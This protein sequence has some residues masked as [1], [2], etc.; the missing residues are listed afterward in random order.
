MAIILRPEQ[1]ADYRETENVT[2]EA[3]WNQYAPGC[4]EHY[5][6]HI[7]RHHNAFLPELDIVAVD[8]KQ[9]IGNIVYV[10]ANI[11]G[12][13]GKEYEVL[14]L[15][16][17]SVLPTY[18]KQG[19]GSKLIYHTKTLAQEM[20]FRAILLCGDP[21]YYAR[22]GFIPAEQFGIRTAE[23][24]YAAALQAYEC[25]PQALAEAKGRYL[26]NEVYQIDVAAAMEFDKNFP[27]KEKICDTPT[28]K[29]FQE[30]VM[31][32]KKA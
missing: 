23:N 10:K 12:D 14:T 26:E 32:D 3:F 7:L 13:N 15:G 11:Q 8:S 2:R 1:P 28:Q 22:F 29:R 19:I 21:A 31:M 5:L 4:M 20:G 24:H 16:P 25:Y 17:I 18:Q 27:P 9:I 6:L 30:L